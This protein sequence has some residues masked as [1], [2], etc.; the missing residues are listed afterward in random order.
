MSKFLTRNEEAAARA[1]VWNDYLVTE[2]F[3]EE[4]AYEM[5]VG[6]MYFDE[7]TR[8]Y[9]LA[10]KNAVTMRFHIER[11]G[12]PDE[13]GY[14]VYIF[15]HGGGQTI[16]NELQYNHGKEYFLDS[17]QNGIYIAIRGVRETYNTHFNPESYPLYD[18]LI[19]NLI[20]F[21]NADPNRIYL[22]GFS[23]G[24]D[25]VYGI[26][27]VMAD[28]FAAVSMSA[29]HHNQISAINYMNTPIILQCGDDDTAYDRH[30]ETARYAEKLKTLQTEWPDGY[31]YEC[32]MHVKKQHQID[33][34]NAFRSEQVVWEDSG[35]WLN[36]GSKAICKNTNAID[37]LNQFT[38][39]PLPK[40][41][42][43]N[44]ENRAPLRLTESFYWLKAPISMNKGVIHATWDTSKNTATITTK[45]VSGKFHIL[46]NWDMADFGQPITLIVNGK[47]SQ[48]KAVPCKE[49]I[50]ETTKDRG[51][52]NYQFSAMVEVTV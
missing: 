44:L 32:D 1:E 16:I 29:G 26:T 17:I 10:E 22:T 20:I 8:T 40:N 37:W 5:H 11:K 51:D 21:R 15:L 18:R 27:P 46:L 6:A 42:A 39:D 52:V 12:L 38:R 25:G 3:N 33:I 41:I 24:G 4:S 43:W 30:L 31:I 34:K 7:A 13:D 50:E 36:G 23:A 49:V 28:R 19:Q 45:D 2:K 48:V 9:S 47:T 35:A 14:P